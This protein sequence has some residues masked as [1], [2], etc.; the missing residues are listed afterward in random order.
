MPPPG[1]RSNFLPTSGTKNQ[2][3]PSALDAS[4]LGSESDMPSQFIWPHHERPCLES[5]QLVVPAID[6]GFV[7]SGADHHHCG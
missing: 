1:E 2:H 5:P 4:I 7:L 3:Q 6:L